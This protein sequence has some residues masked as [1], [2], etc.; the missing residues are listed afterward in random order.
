MK[1]L[2]ESVDSEYE[3]QMTKACEKLFKKLS[4]KE[5]EAIDK[6]ISEIRKAPSSGSNLDDPALKGLLHTHARG[7]SSNILVIWSTEEK[8]KK[9]IIIEGVGPHKIIDWLKRRRKIL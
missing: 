2:P 5:Q 6:R 4:R 8:P 1:T 7:S 9:R 3:V